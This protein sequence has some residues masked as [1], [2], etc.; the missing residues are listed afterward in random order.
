MEART[1]TKGQETA[2][3]GMHNL[4]QGS[5]SGAAPRG[6]ASVPR[7]IPQPAHHLGTLYGTGKATDGGWRVAD[8]GRR[9]T[10]LKRQKH[11]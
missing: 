6:L 4:E 7:D 10:N 11:H 3:S 5:G 2:K 9:S 1:I 8:G